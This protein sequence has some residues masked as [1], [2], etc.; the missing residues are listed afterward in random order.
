[1]VE[2]LSGDLRADV[3]DLEVHVDPVGDRAFV[4]VLHDEVLVEEP[5]GLL[6][7][8][9]VSPSRKASKYSRTC[10]QSV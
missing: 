6:R 4:V 8:V 9:A 2:P 10:R 3:V 7:G 5:E 1:M